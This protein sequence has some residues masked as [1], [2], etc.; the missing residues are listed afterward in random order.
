MSLLV[1][2]S[3]PKGFCLQSLNWTSEYRCQ[4]LCPVKRVLL[5]NIGA[6][7]WKR[8]RIACRVE[9]KQVAFRVSYPWTR[10]CSPVCLWFSLTHLW[11]KEM[12][13]FKAVADFPYVSPGRWTGTAPAPNKNSFC[14]CFSFLDLSIVA[15]GQV[16]FQN[17]R[18]SETLVDRWISVKEH[19][20]F[21]T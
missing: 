6:S 16:E 5:G 9:G 20:L 7:L 19:F 4:G 11:P 3:W 12:E 17:F 1:F 18:D 2:L 21:Q 8:C 15:I 14:L 13:W 10:Q